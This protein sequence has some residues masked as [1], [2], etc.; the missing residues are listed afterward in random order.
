MQN[1]PPFYIGYILVR[2]VKL[3][4]LAESRTLQNSSI[5]FTT[6]DSGH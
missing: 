6:S 3:L 4:R 5:S 1:E 2:Q